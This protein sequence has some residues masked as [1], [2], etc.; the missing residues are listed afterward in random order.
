MCRSSSIPGASYDW[1]AGSGLTPS[2][3]Q[4]Q[5][6]PTGPQ[7]G[8]DPFAQQTTG[9]GSNGGGYIYIEASTPAQQ[10]DFARYDCYASC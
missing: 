2:R 7:T 3:Q 8:F 6:E 4:N 5:Q 1:V 10:G 9:Y